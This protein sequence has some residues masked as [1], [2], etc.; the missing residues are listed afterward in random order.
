M[1]ANHVSPPRLPTL[2]I[3]MITAV[4][5]FA[6]LPSAVHAQSAIGQLENLTG[7]KITKSHTAKTSSLSYQNAMKMQLMSGVASAFL[8]FMDYADIYLNQAAIQQ[9]ALLAKKAAAEKHFKDSVAQVKYEQMMQSYKQL[10]NGN[11]AHFKTLSSSGSLFK[12]LSQSAPMTQAEM[13]RQNILKKGIHITWDYNSWSTILQN[14]IADV[15][16]TVQQEDADQYM[17]KVIDKIETFQG[18]KVAALSGRFMMNIKKETMSYMEDAADAVTSGDVSTMQELG[19]MDLRKM[20]SN[21]LI[22]TGKQTFNAYMEQG[23]GFVT[24][25]VKE[26]NFGLLTAGSQAALK[27][28]GIYTQAA[29]DWKVSLK[30]Y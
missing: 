13:E 22:N 26:K 9:A 27:N 21:A 19:Q 15:P 6:F 10:N 3:A 23:K 20:S 16:P 18:G 5:I 17:G 25:M 8:S 7:Q 14:K 1:K 29:G 4:L 30:K 2:R 24:G 12:T 28:Y 11:T